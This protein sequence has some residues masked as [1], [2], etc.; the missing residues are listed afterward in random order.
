MD[1]L[2]KIDLM[3]AEVK[4]DKKKA[5][6]MASYEKFLSKR[7]DHQAGRINWDTATYLYTTGVSPEQAVNNLKGD[8]YKA[9]GAR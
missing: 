4:F 9:K 5:A 2:D 6:W 7:G 3:I 1:L 8:P